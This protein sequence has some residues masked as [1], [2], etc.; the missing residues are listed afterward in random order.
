[1]YSKCQGG[2]DRKLYELSW[3]W[4]HLYMHLCIFLSIFLLGIALQ[5]CAVLTGLA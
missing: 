2:R 1:M 5:P 4:G 3:V